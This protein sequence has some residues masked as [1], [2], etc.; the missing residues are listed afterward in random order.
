MSAKSARDKGLS[1][2]KVVFTDG[3]IASVGVL[4]DAALNVLVWSVV[5]LDFRLKTTITLVTQRLSL[6]NT[7]PD[8]RR[9]RRAVANTMAAFL[10]GKDPSGDHV[11]GLN[12]DIPW[13]N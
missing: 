12:T 1:Q 9:F 3:L 6:Y 11:R 7:T 8:E 2:R 4:L 10:D 5:C 13:L